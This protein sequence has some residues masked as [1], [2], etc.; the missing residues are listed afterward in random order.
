MKRRFV[1][2]PDPPYDLVEVTTD[3]EPSRADALLYNDRGYDGLR[4]TDGTDISS[5][6]K[7]REYMKKNGLTTMD[8]FKETWAQAAQKRQEYFTTGKG[9]AITR[10]DI[11][12]TIHQLENAPHG[13]R[14]QRR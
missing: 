1:Q 4:A 7:H 11:A 8:D 9:G 6:T 10:E 13:S 2:L 14:K 12:R 5:R 3:R